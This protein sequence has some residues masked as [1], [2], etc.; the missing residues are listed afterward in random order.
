MILMFTK[1]IYLENNKMLYYRD[2]LG[3]GTLHGLERFEEPEEDP[4]KYL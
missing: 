2:R 3:K 4:S 1:H